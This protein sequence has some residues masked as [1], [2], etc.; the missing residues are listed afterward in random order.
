[1]KVFNIVK[2]FGIQM[3]IDFLFSFVASLVQNLSRNPLFLFK[4]VDL[5]SIF[6][7]CLICYT[8]A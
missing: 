8:F 3:V 4:E 7:S 5:V 6:F 2:I 1:M